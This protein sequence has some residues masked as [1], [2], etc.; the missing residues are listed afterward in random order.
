MENV[1]SSK[2]CFFIS[3]FSSKSPIL[4]FAHG[5]SSHIS[6]ANAH[7][8][9]DDGGDGDDDDDDDNDAHRRRVSGHPP[10]RAPSRR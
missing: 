2:S 9:D 1:I 4:I 5:I 7:P 10:M 8:H 3:C 6:P